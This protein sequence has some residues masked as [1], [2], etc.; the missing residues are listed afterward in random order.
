MAPPL[1]SLLGYK[2]KNVREKET[3]EAVDSPEHNRVSL[4]EPNPGG[5]L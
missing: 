3:I 1:L 5:E 2:H 4:A